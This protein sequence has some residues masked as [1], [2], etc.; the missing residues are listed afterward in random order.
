MKRSELLKAIKDRVSESLPWVAYTDMDK[1]QFKRAT[2]EYPVPM[3]ALL[4][5][6]KQSPM[7]SVSAGSQ[8]GSMI[9]TLSLYMDLVTD[10]YEGCEAEDETDTI[11]DRADELWKAMDMLRAGMWGNMV[12]TSE[13]EPLFGLRYMALRS[14]YRIAV[15]DIMPARATNSPAPTVRINTEMYE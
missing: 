4:V 14:E 2:E 7:Q 6:M 10:S 12:R 8:I 9:V 13:L 3:P 11:L 15:K 1:G 5:Q